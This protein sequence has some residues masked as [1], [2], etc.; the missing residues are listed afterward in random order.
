MIQ[1]LGGDPREQQQIF[2]QYRLPPPEQRVDEKG[3]PIE[4]PTCEVCGGIGYIGRIAAFEAIWVT[5]PIRQILLKQPNAEAIEKVARQEGKLPLLT[6]AYK[7][8]LHGITT[9]QE[10]Q[11]VMKANPG[12]AKAAA[13]PD[14]PGA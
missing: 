3:R 9:V 1:Q 10:V 13:K 6:Q 11:R 14:S 7:L 5:D 4:F 12:A 8:V 2:A